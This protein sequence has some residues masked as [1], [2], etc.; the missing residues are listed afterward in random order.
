MTSR[1]DDCSLIG[2]PMVVDSR[3]LSV[4]RIHRGMGWADA[5]MFGLLASD[6]TSRP[7]GPSSHAVP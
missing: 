4:S 7:I 2:L 5:E 3:G 1:L 6:L